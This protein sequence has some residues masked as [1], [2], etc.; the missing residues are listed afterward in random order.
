[1]QLDGGKEVLD[2]LVSEG[3]CRFYGISSNNESLINL[4]AEKGMLEVLQYGSSLLQETLPIEGTVQRYRIGTQVR[5]VMAQCR[6]SGKYFQHQPKWET[7]DHRSH[8]S[9][10]EDFRRYSILQQY[11][12]P[13]YTMAHAAIRYILDKPFNHSICLGAKSLADYETAIQAIEMPPLEEETVC[14]LESACRS[15]IEPR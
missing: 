1:V 7:D 13:G 11:L 3:K 9:G 6:L 15:L 4:M 2:A 14:H 8:R 12:P 10:G 5:G